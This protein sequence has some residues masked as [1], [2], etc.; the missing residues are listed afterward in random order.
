[1]GIS[2]LGDWHNKGEFHARNMWTMIY[3]RDM[4]SIFNCG[5]P[6]ILMQW[7]AFNFSLENTLDEN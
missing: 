6:N 1:M 4:N 3:L 7:G 5:M 2:T